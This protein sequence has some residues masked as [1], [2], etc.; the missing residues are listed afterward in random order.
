[1]KQSFLLAALFAAAA[2]AVGASATFGVQ[3]YVGSDTEFNIQNQAIENSTLGNTSPPWSETSLTADYSGG[4]SGGAEA[5]MATQT[6]QQT[7]PMSRMLK[8]GAG[9]NACAGTNNLFDASGEVIGIDAARVFASSAVVSTALGNGGTVTVANACQQV[10][11]GLKYNESNN[12]VS[13]G[14][15]APFPPTGVGTGNGFQNWRDVLALIYGGLDKDNGLCSTSGAG[16]NPY[17]AI[18]SGNCTTGETCN[19]ITDCTSP[20]RK[21]LAANWTSL[22]ENAGVTNTNGATLTHAWR[23]DDNSGTSDVFSSLL[24]MQGASVDQYNNKISG[25]SISSEAINSFGTSPYCNSLNWDL[26]EAA[27]KT[28]FKG[29]CST[30][31]AGCNNVGSACTGTG[32]G[33]CVSNVDRHYQGPGGLPLPNANDPN[34]NKA[35]GG[36]VSANCHHVPPFA[37]G[38]APDLCPDGSTCTTVG[39]SCTTGGTCALASDNRC[40]AGQTI[41][42]STY[43]SM[44]YGT[45][46][47]VYPTGF[48][49]NDPL[50]VPCLGNGSRSPA[51]DVCNADGNLGLVL[52]IPPLDFVPDQHP[53]VASYTG[54]PGTGKNSSCQKVNTAQPTQC[55]NGSVAAAAAQVYSCAP[56]GTLANGLCPNNDVPLSIGC[57]VPEGETGTNSGIFTTQCWSVS[58]TAVG[59]FTGQGPTG[60]TPCANIDGR[61]YNAQVYDGT[62]SATGT[63]QY[64]NFT[65][66]GV[67]LNHTAAYAR[68]H[69]KD[70]SVAG[71]SVCQLKDATQQIGC[72]AQADPNSIG[73]GGNTG[74][75]WEAADSLSLGTCSGETSGLRVHTVSS[76]TACTPVAPS[77]GICSSGAACTPVGSTTV[78]ADKSTCASAINYPLWRKLYMN[79]II[80]FGNI[81]TTA[82][83][84]P[85]NHAAE[86]ELAGW[87]AQAADISPIMLQYGEFELGFGPNGVNG[88]GLSQPFCE[89]FNEYGAGCGGGTG[90][91]AGNQN[92]CCTN[93]SISVTIGSTTYT[94]PS[95]PSCNGGNATTPSP[96]GNAS[97]ASST[98]TVCGNGV[99]EDYEDCDPGTSANGTG[100][101][102]PAAAL[103]TGCGSCSSTCRCS[104]F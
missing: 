24:G 29:F 25:Y 60:G 48:Q 42:T 91:T 63:T 82:T 37:C 96:T 99:I 61:V 53:G 79:S 20:R 73:Y 56:K 2:G 36:A 72:L 64:I 78:C 51:E 21:A 5:A 7:G 81:S 80:G 39:A 89:D 62:A 32:T 45:Q 38:A 9:A 43:G 83:A 90:N 102:I 44:D 50:R 69:Q 88:T 68:I 40:P 14:N 87:E 65:V 6:A 86:I 84:P 47:N 4:G 8:G 46:S 57:L 74:D 19:P 92:A 33:T 10:T 76:G 30:N 27:A 75:V 101:A 55:Q 95:D 17:L 13:L 70:T 77:G 22:F 94:I 49:D 98:S 12:P 59:C 67:P 34:C 104:L 93:A 18:G 66:G 31:F 23:R 41:I 85:S 28:C 15:S 26:T 54:S 11:A 52:P 97:A 16:C 58:S 3:P 103:P 71:L 35:V 100:S 1:M